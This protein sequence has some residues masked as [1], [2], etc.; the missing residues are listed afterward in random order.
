MVGVNVVDGSAVGHKIALEAP[1]IPQ[2]V[3]DQRHGAAGIAVEPVV[4]PH[5]AGDLRL[6][7]GP[8]K[9]R[10]IGLPQIML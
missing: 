5:D 8:F 6:P 10:Q 2:H 1:F 9:G 3:P 4:G 7:H